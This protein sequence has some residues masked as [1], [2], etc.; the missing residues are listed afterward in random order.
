[1]LQFTIP[2][3][4]RIIQPEIYVTIIVHTPFFINPAQQV[5]IQGW[6]VTMDNIKQLT[7]FI[8][9]QLHILEEKV[10][11][12]TSVAIQQLENIKAESERLVGGLFE[13]NSTCLNKNN[14]TFAANTSIISPESSF[15][16]M[17][18]YGMLALT[19]LPEHSCARKYLS[20]F[21]ILTY[22]LY[23]TYKHMHTHMQTHTERN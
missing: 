16:N 23:F 6:L 4:K 10:A 13:E 17:L 2:G 7:N 19:L 22:I 14:N 15:I 8:E 18:R 1:M 5:L 21:Y 9:N 3:S 20:Y 12:V 11:C